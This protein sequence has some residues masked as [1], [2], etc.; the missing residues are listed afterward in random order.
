MFHDVDPAELKRILAENAAKLYDFDLDAF[1]PAGRS[2]TGR[3]SAE[4]AQ[5]LAEL[6][7]NPNSALLKGQGQLIA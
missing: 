4:I 2:S 7:E 6:P 1:A 5:P 3:P